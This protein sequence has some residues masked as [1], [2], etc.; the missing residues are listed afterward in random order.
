MQPIRIARAVSIGLLLTLAT[1][2]QPGDPLTPVT[3]G[4]VRDALLSDGGAVFKGIPFAPPPMR[5]LRGRDAQP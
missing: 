3:G 4:R 5:D 1:G 2:A